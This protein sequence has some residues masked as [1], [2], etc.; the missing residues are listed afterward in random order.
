MKIIRW[1]YVI[2]FEVIAIALIILLQIVGFFWKPEV[3]QKFSKKTPVLLISGYV[4]TSAVWIYLFWK[5]AKADIGPIYRI[6]LKNPFSSIVDLAKQVEKMAGCIEE[7]TG[8]PHL[9]IIGHSMGGLVGAYY[10]TKIA[11]KGKV[12]DVITLGSPWSGSKVAKIAI[13]KNAREMDIDSMF[14]GTLRQDIPHSKIRFF[15]IASMT[16]PFIFPQSSAILHGTKG[17]VFSN[18]GHGAMLFS[19]RVAKVLIEWIRQ[20]PQL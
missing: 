11:K 1:I 3:K 17:Y 15:H 5:L 4:N 16:D 10:A 13:G 20:I 7:E 19:P 12:T 14:L 8:N 18:L 2:I 9:I 6:N